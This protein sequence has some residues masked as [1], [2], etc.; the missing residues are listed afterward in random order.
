MMK[1]TIMCFVI[2]GN[3]VT[4][5]AAAPVIQQLPTE[6][7]VSDLESGSRL[8]YIYTVQDPNGNSFTCSN[9]ISAEK[10]GVAV[11]GT[12]DQFDVSL[13]ALT[14]NYELRTTGLTAFDF[15]TI[16][17]FYN[18]LQCT[19]INAEVSQALDVE[20]NVVDNQLVTV[21]NAEGA[22]NLLTLNALG[23]GQRTLVK[24]ID[25]TSSNDIKYN[26]TIDPS[27]SPEFFV[28]DSS[29][30]EIRTNRE[31]KYLDS[32]VPTLDF[33]IRAY[34]TVNQIEIFSTQT[35]NLDN[36]NT[37]PTTTNMITPLAETKI[38]TLAAGT[39]LFTIS[40]SDPDT[41]QTHTYRYTCTPKAA[42][43]TFELDTSGN[44]KIATGKSL[45]YERNPFF[46]CSFWIDDGIH[47]GGPFI[48]ELTVEN[49]NEAP[50]FSN[51]MYHV[52]TPE[53]AK[54]A[55]TF[56]ASFDCQDDDTGDSITYDFRA[57][58]NSDRFH[59]LPSGLIEFNVDYDVDNAYPTEEVLTVYCIDSGHIDGNPLTGSAQVTITV[60]D[61]NDNEPVFSSSSYTF[62]VTD[63]TT[64]GTAIGVMA[65]TDADSTTNGYVRCSASS[66]STY[67]TYFAIGA[68]CNVY[69]TRQVDFAAGT[70][71]QYIVTAIDDGNPQLTGTSTVAIIYQQTPTTTT[72][73][74]PTTTPYN[75][76]DHAGNI[77]LFVFCLLM[78]LA[79]LGLL[80]W[81]LMQFC[82]PGMCNCFGRGGRSRRY[83]D[84]RRDDYNNDR[85]RDDYKDNRRRD[86]DEYD[87]PKRKDDKST[88]SRW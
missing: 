77:V 15:A 49:N 39:T 19:D 55:T 5:D 4:T 70:Q 47:E 65:V 43:D 3:I 76:F 54:G 27:V 33:S 78:A 41:S 83:P 36:Q 10:D 14:G 6:K 69:S 28:I 58:N 35:V 82:C 37:I 61:V 72:T 88:K 7:Y 71:T 11:P 56:D 85:R 13:N 84:R 81:C 16:D 59:V 30:G 86:S 48:Y 75:F 67:S 22:A 57:I 31:L 29:T 34:D 87:S 1:L 23:V 60:T 68:N 42:E 74:A 26:M 51:I 32:S 18:T 66:G 52:S 45:N 8:L 79:L 38:E 20:V 62:I 9:T 40:T 73:P 2:L 44:F 46:N 17:K 25:S 24:T 53:G 21:N 50:Y 63:T 12:Y 80:T 64:P